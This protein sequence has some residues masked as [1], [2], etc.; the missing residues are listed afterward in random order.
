MSTIQEFNT[1][2]SQ[3]GDGHFEFPSLN[4]PSSREG[5]LDSVE[6]ESSDWLN[7]SLAGSEFSEASSRP[8]SAFRTFMSDTNEVRFIFC[9]YVYHSI[10]HHFIVPWLGLSRI[11]HSSNKKTP[12]LFRKLPPKHMVNVVSVCWTSISLF[13]LQATTI[14][15]FKNLLKT[16][17]FTLFYS[18]F[19]SI[20]CTPTQHYM[21]YIYYITNNFVC[22]TLTQ[23]FLSS[24][25]EYNL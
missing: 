20:Y 17:L 14:S 9:P 4:R 1:L 3:T 19:C 24:H 15:H 11:L 8:F 2:L 23:V 10:I 21:I 6:P 12:L 5:D 18:L 16:F 25:K 7:Q 22:T 13:T